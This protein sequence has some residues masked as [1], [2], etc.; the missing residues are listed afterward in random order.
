MYP[1]RASVNQ[2]PGELLSTS[3]PSID[4][5]WSKHEFGWHVS[6]TQNHRDAIETLEQAI[7][8][9]ERLLGRRCWRSWP[10]P[11]TGEIRPIALVTDN[12]FCFKAPCFATYID[13]RPELIHIRT[14]HR[15][16]QQS[17]VANEHS[18]LQM[19][20]QPESVL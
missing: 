19:D 14:G 6:T 1:V 4:D 18:V 15:S 8:E 3:T 16:P 2:R 13:R 5:G 7:A 11:Q 9:T 20:W 10:S 12:G 17:G